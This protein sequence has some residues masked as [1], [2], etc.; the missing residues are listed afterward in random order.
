MAT[1]INM[2]MSAEEA[3]E[4]TQPSVAEAPKYPWGLN[5]RLDD[6]AMA[7]LGLSTLEVGSEVMIVAKAK[8]TSC[9]S[10]EV[11]GGDSESSCELQITD[12]SVAAS[13]SAEDALYPSMK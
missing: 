9:S 3:K 10:R 5:I 2:Q 7:K 12:M 1:L 8:C 4:E 13:S 6:D 11:Q